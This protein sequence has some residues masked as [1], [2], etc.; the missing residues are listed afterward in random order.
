M[1][2][3][4]FESLEVGKGGLPPLLQLLLQESGGEPP[5]LTCEFAI[6]ESYTRNRVINKH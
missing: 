1:K 4:M 5:F 2:T 3:H 6:V